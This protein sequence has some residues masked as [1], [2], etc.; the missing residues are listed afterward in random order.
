MHFSVK[1]HAVGVAGIERASTRTAAPSQATSEMSE[2]TG[3][4]PHRV[5]PR[6]RWPSRQGTG[7]NNPVG[8][9]ESSLLVYGLYNSSVAMKRRVG[10]VALFLLLG[11]IINIAIAW[12]CVLNPWHVRNTSGSLDLESQVQWWRTVAPPDMSVPTQA[13]R[14]H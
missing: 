13:D 1:S 12:T 4:T 11:A 7:T 9:N 3:G 5:D 2:G 6:K 10:K 8:W 14:L